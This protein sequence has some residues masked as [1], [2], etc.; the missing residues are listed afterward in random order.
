MTDLDTRDEWWSSCRERIKLEGERVGGNCIF[1]YRE[2][3][4]IDKDLCV[5]SCQGTAI[6]I[7]EYD[8]LCLESTSLALPIMHLHVHTNVYD[9]FDIHKNTL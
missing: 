4:S 5:L 9:P 7:G 8:P 2:T 1:S 3:C 6:H